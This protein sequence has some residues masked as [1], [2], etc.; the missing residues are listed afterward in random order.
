MRAVFEGV[1]LHSHV[2]SLLLDGDD[3]VLGEGHALAKG[4]DNKAENIG[5][6]IHNHVGNA[7]KV[8]DYLLSF[9]VALPSVKLL[10]VSEYAEELFLLGI[11]KKSELNLRLIIHNG[12][13]VRCARTRYLCYACRQDK[14][15]FNHLVDH[16]VDVLLA[17]LSLHRLDCFL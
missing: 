11:F 3:H 16:I 12:S 17:A 7:V 14:L 10:D 8:G 9:L 5:L 4:I 13:S 2:I 15:G 6:R 1:V